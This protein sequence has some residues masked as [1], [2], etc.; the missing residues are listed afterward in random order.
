MSLFAARLRE[1]KASR[2]MSSSVMAQLIGI[3]DDR[4]TVYENAIAEPTTD[5]L[6]KIA[7]VFGVSV[8]YLTGRSSCSKLFFDVNYEEK[9]ILEKY[10]KMTPHDKK[11][12]MDI[13]FNV[14]SSYK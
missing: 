9:E 6:N 3:T 2:N 12:F 10:R 14:F 7:S 8:D 11:I 5:E 13:L 4:M 1:L